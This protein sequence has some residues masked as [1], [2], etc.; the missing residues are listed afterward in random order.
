VSVP[1]ILA[2][3]WLGGEE[4]TQLSAKQLCSGSIPL[5]ASHF[6][7]RISGSRSCNPLKAETTSGTK[8]LLRGFDSLLRLIKQIR[9]KTAMQGFPCILPDLKNRDMRFKSFTKSTRSEIPLI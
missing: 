4:V 3:K 2:K 8:H 5:R 7:P 1:E 6:L 9:D